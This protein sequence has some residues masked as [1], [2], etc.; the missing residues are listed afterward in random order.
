MS[1]ESTNSDDAPSLALLMYLPYRA[2]EKRVLDG[3][4]AAGV[5]DISVAQARVLQR[6]GP[7][8]TRLTDLAAQAN[9]T[10]QTAGFLVEQLQRNGYLER[11]PDPRDGR[12]RVIALSPKAEALLPTAAAI[13][14]EI[15]GE[16]EQH[17]GPRRMRQLREG[18][19]LLREITDPYRED[20]PAAARS[21]AG[22]ARAV[23][24]SARRTG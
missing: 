10:K 7:N 20:V 18:L 11:R 8:G 12:A 17:L 6:V 23:P 4:A 16:W 22:P 24:A 13:V 15:E 2:T 21:A 1:G 3:L 9:V 5:D 14:A 19:T